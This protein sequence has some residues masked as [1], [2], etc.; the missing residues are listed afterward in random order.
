[1]K[2]YNS[3]ISLPPSIDMMVFNL[4][5]CRICISWPI[6]RGPPYRF[7]QSFPKISKEWRAFSW[8]KV[9]TSAFTFKTLCRHQPTKSRQEI[10]TSTQRKI[11]R[12]GLHDCEIFANLR[13][14]LF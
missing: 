3:P 5:K 12:N 4:F 13:L 7:K 14:K 6:C 10:G 1:M 9:P 8:L 11:I 2:T